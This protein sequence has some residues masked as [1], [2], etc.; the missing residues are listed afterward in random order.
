MSTQ[1][2]ETD[3]GL[4]GHGAGRLAA[5]HID[6]YNAELRDEEGFIGNRASGRTFQAILE[7]GRERVRRIDQDPIG[8]VPSE[9][10]SKKKLERLMADS[11]PAAV[12][13]VLGAIETSA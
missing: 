8:E 3:P 13:V 7:N 6:T 1:V 2:S 10:I 4:D 5:V 12:G 11:D 9:K